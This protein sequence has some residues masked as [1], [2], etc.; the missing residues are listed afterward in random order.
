MADITDKF[1]EL[2]QISLGNKER[3]EQ[4]PS[5]KEWG[6]LFQLSCKHSMAGV[7]FEGFKKTE[8]SVKNKCQA[9]YYEWYA[10]P[11]ERQSQGIMYVSVRSRVP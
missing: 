5:E 9:L 3:F 1:F 11:P 8:Q 7:L 10:A 4:P 6:M 2:I